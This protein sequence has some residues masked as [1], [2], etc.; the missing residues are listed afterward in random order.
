MKVILMG[1]P[2]FVVPM[3]DAISESHDVIAVF[4]RGPKPVGRKHVITKSPVHIWAESKNIP[5]YHKPGE[6]N[7]KPDMVFVAAY[8]A[9]LHKNVL[10]S[11]PCINLHPSLL[12]LYRGPSPIKTAILNGDTESGVCLMR[13]TE[14]L[15]AG[16]ILMCQKFNIEIDDT[17]EVI[18]K[19]V[20]E[21][22]S[23]MI[24]E[25]MKNPNKYPP[26]KQSGKI[27]YTAKIGVYDEIIDWEKSPIEIHNLVR[28]LG[29][30]RTKI[31]GIDVKILKTKM[32][33]D[34]L[35][36]VKIQPAGKKP[37]D[38]KSFVN[39]LRGAEIK[40]GE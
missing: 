6:Y 27:V 4:T 13:M 38:W 17:N 9:I 24:L 35:E 23:K 33:G 18:E 15:D 21:I 34:T 12:P 37:M 25:Y 39:G 30:G 10:N 20:S 36:I 26:I 29:A 7:F 31:N 8:G 1:T 3:F 40:Y 22:G 16:D 2:D 5:V 32:N 14:E 19:H 11:A 28:A